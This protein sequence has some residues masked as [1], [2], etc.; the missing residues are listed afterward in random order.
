MMLV[1]ALQGWAYDFEVDGIYYII[2]GT[3]T[4]SVVK[5]EYDYGGDITIPK[6]VSSDGKTYNVTAIGANA[7]QSAAAEGQCIQHV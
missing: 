3:N 5:G 6:N 4:V 1:S 7:F 2:T